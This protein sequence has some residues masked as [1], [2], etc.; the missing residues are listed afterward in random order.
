MKIGAALKQVRVGKNLTQVEVCKKTG[1]TQTYLS[2]IET[3]GKKNPSSTVVAKLCKVYGVPVSVVVVLATEEKD[4]PKN[5][6]KL[7]RQLSP[8]LNDLVA[9]LLK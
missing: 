3:G 4:I 8:V 9:Q 7:Y 5:R 2:Q 6:L 1:L